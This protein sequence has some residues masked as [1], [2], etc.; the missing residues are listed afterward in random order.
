MTFAEQQEDTRELRLALAL[1][2]GASMAVWIGGAVCEVDRLRRA[3]GSTADQDSVWA[4][5][6][7]LAGYDSVAIDV[8]AGASAGGLNAALLTAS[9]VYGQS[10]ERTRR[11][12]VRLADIE[13]MARKTPAFWQPRPD[14]LLEGD[15]YFR[16]ELVEVL[17]EGGS[18]PGGAP[19]RVDLLLTATLLDPAVVR[20]FDGRDDPVLER[21]RRA[22]F[23][24]RH[25]GRPGDP[26]SDF[27][28]GEQFQESVLR[29]AHAARTTSS[30]PFA[31]E[32]AQVH[33]APG[34]PPA[35]EPN[36][37]GF[38]S[39]SSASPQAVPFRVVDG[40]V[41][42]NIPVTAAV[43][44]IAE[45]PADRPTDRWLLYLNPD[46]AVSRGQRPAGWSIPVAA[47]AVRA[48]FSRESLL[49]DIKALDEH[50]RAAERA[51]LRRQ[52][53]FA[54]VHSADP[55]HRAAVLAEQARA[56]A[57]ENSRVRA[58]LDAQAVHRLLTEPAGAEDGTLLPP[59]AGDPLHGWSA[60]ARSR[61]P[62][63]L[64]RVLTE[65]ADPELFGDVHGLRAAVHE[66]LG[67]V[68]DI[69]RSAVDPGL[70]SCKAALYRLRV[71]AEV[72]ESHADRYWVTGAQ[73]EPIVDVGELDGWIQRMLHRRRRL[74]HHLPSPVGPLL[75]AVL[76]AVETGTDFQ[77]ELA[78]FS[79]ELLS[80]VESCG[81]DA[82]PAAPG[83]DAVAAAWQVLERIADRLAGAAPRRTREPDV[84]QV[85]YAVLEDS[86]RRGEVLRQLVTITAPLNSVREPASRINFLRI[87]SDQPCALPFRALRR[88]ADAPLRVADRVRGTDLGHFG[89]FLSAKWRANDWMWGRLDAAAGL[90]ELLTD[91][92]RWAR[93]HRSAEQLSDA[94][95][96]LVRTPGQEEL[97]WL[98][99]DSAQWRAFLSELWS[100]HAGEVR[101]ELAALFADPDGHHPLT[102][103]RR[104]LTE[105]VQW[106]I[107]AEEIPFIATVAAG[108]DPTGGGAPEPM[109][110]DR[111]TESVEEYDVGRQRLR[112]LPE[113]RRLSAITRLGVLAHRVVRPEGGGVAGWAARFAITALKPLWLL[114]LFVLAAPK[115]A[116]LLGWL[117]AGAVAFTGPGV[118]GEPGIALL[119]A[120]SASG[121]LPG[122][123]APEGAF[124]VLDRS[125]SAFG[126][127]WI[128]LLVAAVCAMWLG[129]QL[130]SASERGAA[131]WFPAVAVAVLVLGGGH[132]ALQSTEPRL[133]PLGL[134][135]VAGA[136]TWPALAAFRP[137]A[138]VGGVLVTLLAFGVC[139]WLSRFG[140]DSGSWVLAGTVVAACGQALWLSSIDPFAP[141]PRGT[142]GEPTE[143]APE[144]ESGVDLVGSATG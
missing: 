55:G 115:R 29:L 120:D 139:L 18:G 41:L 15:D 54:P 91:P 68:W 138:R 48:R 34:K 143:R 59:V 111:L 63:R 17:A 142:A 127:A 130:G 100:R 86:E 3:T 40:G 81:A 30:Y 78:D 33:S 96:Q 53:I 32:P 109:G 58:E 126:G 98:G 104:M 47:A 25:L 83:V 123:G 14:S 114:V 60:A 2:G 5:L 87:V 38:F 82:D 110:P 80:I 61:L 95:E 131:K 20:Y 71:L 74:Q 97:T 73:T 57:V 69:E 28:T 44:A 1:R 51:Q 4:G 52:A 56:A 93:R 77:R 128:A 117:G 21:R 62:E 125:G 9:L 121:V 39:E 119:P 72:L 103:T 42:D 85:G 99:G 141:R 31:F 129:V 88:G 50:N 64:A 76:Q 13:A 11:M 67:W 37:L 132:W 75:G 89:A 134:V 106:L 113:R 135:L 12:W 140:T 8:L 23:R 43:K 16:R 27:G 122:T 22:M 144:G 112:S 10:F 6:A 36:M 92:V 7:R 49:T 45:A 26:L 19:G 46:P 90:V 84:L 105:R 133:G 116:A 79:R 94:L 101:E 102:G 136:L 118:V 70:G 24:F 65:A 137:L 35:G 124:A 66:C 108:A 107:A